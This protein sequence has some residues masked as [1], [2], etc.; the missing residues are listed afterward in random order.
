MGL[1]HETEILSFLAPAIDASLISENFLVR[2]GSQ[3]KVIRDI[4]L[5]GANYTKITY[6]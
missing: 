1:N 4:E 6:C 5:A 2:T 3:E